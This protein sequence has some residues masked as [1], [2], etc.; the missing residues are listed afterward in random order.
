MKKKAIKDKSKNRKK[1]SDWQK[2]NMDKSDDAPKRLPGWRARLFEWTSKDKD[3]LKL[4]II[5]LIPFLVLYIIKE[6][7]WDN[8]KQIPG[9]LRSLFHRIANEHHLPFTRKAIIAL[10]AL[11]LLIVWQYVISIFP[12]IVASTFFEGLA[13]RGL[14]FWASVAAA[15]IFFGEIYDADGL[16]GFVFLALSWVVLLF[17]VTFGSLRIEKRLAK[18]EYTV[19]IGRIADKYCNYNKK[20]G[21]TCMIYTFVNNESFSF[22]IQKEK[23]DKLELGDTILIL[24][25]ERGGSYIWKYFPTHKQIEKYKVPQHYINGKLQEKPPYG[26]YSATERDSLLRLSHNQIGFVFE[27]TDDEYFRHLVKVGTDAEYTTTHE[28]YETD[29]DYS[30]VYK[31]LNVGD[32]VILQVSYSA[33]EVNRVLCWHPDEA[34]IEKYI[35]Y[36]PLKDYSHCGQQFEDELLLNSHKRLAFVYDKY[37]DG[38]VGAYLEVGID[39]KHIR[40]YQFKTFEKEYKEI[41]KTKNIGDAVVVQVSDYIPQLNRVLNWNPSGKEIFELRKPQRLTYRTIAYVH[42]KDH[43]K[44]TNAVG[45]T[46]KVKEV[47]DAYRAKLRVGN[48]ITGD[49]KIIN[50]FDHQIYKLIKEGDPVLAQMIM[51]DGKRTIDVLNWRPTPEEL[52]KFKQPITFDDDNVQPT[53]SVPMPESDYYMQ[54]G[55]IF[56]KDLRGIT[57]QFNT[58]VYV[59]VKKS[60]QWK[61]EMNK[62]E[63]IHVGDTILLM[64]SDRNPGY[65]EVISW[66]PTPEEKQKYMKPVRLVEKK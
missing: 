22:D 26:Q 11:V 59:G 6:E 28:F 65:N 17:V 25:S 16:K 3:F 41:Y 4:V 8:R 32:T 35:S 20:S 43:I 12:S 24:L 62:F 14:Y 61:H 63:N 31:R 51:K 66:C 48:T 13:M 5:L 53:D 9:R 36:K 10:V 45:T 19:H 34:D 23:Y 49:I 52:D 7:L 1:I 47:R 33:P 57:K 2:A 54:T 15:S 60:K 39:K 27:I 29:V 56:R 40:T 55:Y 21:E 50:P 18:K 58:M 30:K 42:S 38:Q 44:E 46:V 64:L 37:Q